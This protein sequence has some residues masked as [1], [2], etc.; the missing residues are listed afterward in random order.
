MILAIYWWFQLW[1]ILHKL[2]WWTCH[3][4][5]LCFPHLS[6][7]E[8][9]VYIMVISNPR[10]KVCCN[11]ETYYG[12]KITGAYFLSVM[13]TTRQMD[14]SNRIYCG[15]MVLKRNTI[16]CTYFLWCNSLSLCRA[17][18]FTPLDATAF[19]AAN[20]QPRRMIAARLRSLGGITRRYRYR[21]SRG[22][23]SWHMAWMA[24]TGLMAFFSI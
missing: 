1:T 18:P 12:L 22:D 2:Y 21:Q 8:I 19:S 4:A 10:V 11:S 3:Q 23:N 24:K 15:K 20:L 17:I 14:C 9:T 7:K 16:K 6:R 5:F 13:K